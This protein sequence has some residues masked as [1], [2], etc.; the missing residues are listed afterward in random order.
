V[1]KEQKLQT[2]RFVVK[3]SQAAG[4]LIKK[5]VTAGLLVEEATP[6]RARLEQLFLEQGGSD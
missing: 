6:E 5:L 2:A 1:L 4:Y 3:D